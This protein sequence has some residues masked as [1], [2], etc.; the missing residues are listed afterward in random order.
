MNVSFFEHWPYAL[1]RD[2]NRDCCYSECFGSKSKPFSFGKSE[3]DLRTDMSI[4]E[5]FFV[6]KE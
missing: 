2:T 3:K 6:K 1:P 4:E 5:M